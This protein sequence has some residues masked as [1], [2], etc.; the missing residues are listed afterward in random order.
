MI[1]ASAWRWGQLLVAQGVHVSGWAL[2][3]SYL[4]ATFFNNFLPSNI[5]G[6][7]V[8]IRDTSKPM[9]SKTLAA[10]VVLVDRAIGLIGLL[11]VA[12]A[13]ATLL[14]Q[15]ATRRGAGLAAPALAGECSRASPGSP[16]W[17][18]R[19]VAVPVLRPLRLRAPPSGSIFVC[20]GSRIRC[21]GSAGTRWRSSTASSAPWPCRPCSC[22]STL[23]VATGLAIPISVVHLAVLVPLSFVVQMVPV[24]LNGFG[25]REA[26]FTYYFG[27]LGLP[28]ESAL[29]LS[30]VGTAVIM[31]FSLSGAAAYVV[32]AI[33]RRRRSPEPPARGSSTRRVWF[34][35]SMS[36]KLRPLS[37]APS[38]SLRR[39]RLHQQ[40]SQ[41]QQPDRPDQHRADGRAHRDAGQ[42]AGR[43]EARRP[44]PPR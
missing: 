25:V 1:L 24:S 18:S 15:G 9:G 31:V 39:L 4:V 30:L 21:R 35:R 11:L 26:T 36:V 27:M 5:G 20:N 13:G 14:G 22:S 6:D 40:R 12:S 29:L 19:R 23:A 7:V 16:P 44:S 42:P 32:G 37:I 8:R 10:T 34:T 33:R 28:I 3:Q 43:V 2:T 38:F 41:P 17:S